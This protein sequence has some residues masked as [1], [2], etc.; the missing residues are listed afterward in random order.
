[1]HRIN[2]SF[3]EKSPD[4]TWRDVQHL[5]A[6]TAKIPNPVEPGWAINGAGYHIHHR[7]GFGLLDA[8]L[9]VQQAMLFQT[10]PPHRKCSQE[11]TF[12]P[13]RILPP[14]GVVS[15]HIQSDGCRGTDDAL[16]SLE[17]VQ[18]TVSITSVCRGDLS[19]DL[20]SPSSTCSQLLG[21]RGND[22]SAAGLR[23][24]TLMTVQAWGEEP[25]GTWR[26]KV[27]DNKG[28][29]AKCGRGEAEEAAGAVLSATFT[30]Y[31]AL[32]PQRPGSSGPLETFVSMGKRHQIPL[33]RRG[34]WGE[35][36]TQRLIQ[37]E[38]EMESRWKVTADDI[39]APLQTKNTKL[40]FRPAQSFSPQDMDDTNG[41]AFRAHLEQLWN[42]LRSKVESN[43]AL[44]KSMAKTQSPQL[45]LTDGALQRF[46]RGEPKVGV[47]AIERLLISGVGVASESPP[48]PLAQLLRSVASD[49]REM[50][51]LKDILGSRGAWQ[52]RWGAGGTGR[53]K[54]GVTHFHPPLPVSA[55]PRERTAP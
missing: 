20:I 5:I 30:L 39:P 32:D 26:L 23:N 49:V 4:L 1:M 22:A 8:G 6:K 10:M 48:N 16:N 47:A 44:Y 25:T 19:V 24:W 54:R 38:F 55:T 36:S 2:T 29:V 9:M 34:E 15:V 51:H 11:M 7:Y 43:W 35:V 53:E 21:P 27:T 45:R 31:G 13:V 17:H 33:S 28:T 50:R 41:E 40:K 42:T 37:M 12:D 14:G 52:A 3:M 46:L 18:V